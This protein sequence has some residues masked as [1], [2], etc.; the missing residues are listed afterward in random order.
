M[1]PHPQAGHLPTEKDLVHIP[2]LM[3]AYYTLFPDLKEPSQQVSFGTSGHRGSS[4]QHTFNEQ[5]ICAITQAV[6]DYR[7]SN[8]ITGP[9]FLGM[10]THALSEAA[11]RTALEVLV[12]NGVQVFI[13]KDGAYTPTPA[14][15]R[16]ILR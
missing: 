1:N 3:A 10:D 14:V 9:L 16:A 6:C 7:Q 13:A 8:S 11:C 4:L 2:S 15:T 12:G 5:H